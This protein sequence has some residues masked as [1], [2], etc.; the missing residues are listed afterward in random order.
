MEVIKKDGT[1]EPFQAIK[2][3][4]A[5]TKS[6]QRAMVELTDEDMADIVCGVVQ[7]LEEFSFHML[8]TLS[9][10]VIHYVLEWHRAVPSAS[11]RY[12]VRW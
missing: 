5:V 7:E 1:K 9:L 10:L 4:N 6:A 8:H 2:I 11:Y 12:Y 3:A